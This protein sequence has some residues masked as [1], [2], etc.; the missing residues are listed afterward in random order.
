MKT[1]LKVDLIA[2]TRPNFVKIAAL[3]H[4][5]SKE[6]SKSIS[7]RLIHTGQHYSHSLSGQFFKQLEI[8]NP[9]INFNVGSGTQAHQTGLIMKKYEG[10][11]KLSKPHLCIVV[12]DVTSS[13]AI[14]IT[15]K[16]M[17]VRLAHVEAGIRSNDHSMPEE[18]N[19][20]I[21]DSIA[22]YFFTTTRSASQLLI[23]QGQNAENIFFVGNTMIDTLLKFKDKLN[24]PA[25]YD[26]LSLVKNKYL[27]LTLHRPSNVDDE[28]TL[29]ETL[30]RIAD[31]TNGFPI[32]FPVHPRTKK[33]LKCF[34]LNIPNV[35][36]IEPLPYL[37]FIYL[38]KNTKCILTDSGGITEEATVLDIPCITLRSNT[39]RPETVDL[40]TNELV[41]NDPIL[42]AKA[43]KKLFDGKWKKGIAPELWDG[44][45]GRRIINALF[46]KV[47]NDFSVKDL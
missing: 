4:A 42:I 44:H 1:P 16:K 39:E 18:I 24:K 27:L 46:E 21:I 34:S 38:L 33:I 22:D 43:L 29:I 15:A 20:L 30:E 45:T 23:Q 19:R 28:Q 11:L 32:I 26:S 31:L 14:A 47:M 5:I 25:I 10:L 7:I 6:Q 8:P 9:E 37:E 41:G 36:L 40:G 2:G 13:M 12:G 17:N 35:N 3:I